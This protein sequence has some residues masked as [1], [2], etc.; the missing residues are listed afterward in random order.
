MSEVPDEPKPA[1]APAP[2]APGADYP[3]VRSGA[4]LRCSDVDRERVAEAL[5]QAAGDGRLTLTELEERLE[6]TFKARTYGELQPIT[7][8]LPQGPYPVPGGNPAANWQ[9]GRPDAARVAPV[10]GAGAQPPLPPSGGPVRPS[11]RITSVLSNEKRQG[12][13]EV[14]ARIDVTSILGEV[15]LDFTEAVVRTPEVEIQTSIVLGSLTMIVPEGIDVRIDEGTN[16]LGERKMKLREP[17][18]PGAPVYRVRGFVLLG[19]VTVRPPRDKRRSF[20]GH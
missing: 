7:R 11:E 12:R 16:I 6:A 17:V 1:P 9:A 8:D 4:D 18:T 2:P 19:E 20:L 10:A 3:D 13:W 14:P 15:V 5:R